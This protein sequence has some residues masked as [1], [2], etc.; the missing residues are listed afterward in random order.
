VQRFDL[1][2]A[3]AGIDDSSAYLSPFPLLADDGIV[4]VAVLAEGRQ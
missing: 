2:R 4:R 3:G 1:R